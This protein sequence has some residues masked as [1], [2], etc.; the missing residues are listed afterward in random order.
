[1]P[2][3]AAVGIRVKGLRTMARDARST[4]NRLD[5]GIRGANKKSAERA[6]VPR[7]RAAAPRRSGALANSVRARATAQRAQIIVGTN[8]KVP[9]AGPINFGWPLRGIR[10]Q[11][12]IYKS[13]AAAEK[14]MLDIY[15]FEIDKAT[16][17]IAPLGKL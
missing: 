2:P 3:P 17:P 16:R 1:M 13:I 11:E 14:E 9:Y 4:I 10:A 15:I 5:K 12:F 8:V 7:I 6:L